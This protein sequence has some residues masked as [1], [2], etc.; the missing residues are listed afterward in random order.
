MIYQADLC[1]V[2]NKTNEP[3]GEL[4]N[5]CAGFILRVNGINILTS[6][7][8]YQACRFPGLTEAQEI[9]IQQSSPMAAKMK[10]KPYRK[11]HNRTDWDEVHVDIMRW[12]L[13]VKLAQNFSSFAKIL[14][15]TGHKD[16]V[17]KS[18]KDKFWGAVPQ[19]NNADLLEGE[20]ILGKLLME[21]REELYNSSDKS[22]LLSVEPLDI[23][24][25]LLY[26]KPIGVVSK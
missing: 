23:P 4:S 18:H 24:D 11:N 3:F 2:F 20:N 1:C 12:C 22:K 15:S 14:R 13:K 19:K 16:I 25:F 8:L 10:S 21:L 7:A 17:E 9:I 5:M 26:G 6:E